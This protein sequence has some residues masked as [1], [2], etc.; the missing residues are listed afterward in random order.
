MR[1]TTRILTPLE[2]GC[3]LIMMA[4]VSR[5]QARVKNNRMESKGS[6]NA[7]WIGRPLREGAPKRQKFKENLLLVLQ[8]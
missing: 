6:K 5:I 4:K 1:T 8:K 3:N 2:S 7:S